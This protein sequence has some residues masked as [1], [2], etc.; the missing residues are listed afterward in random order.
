[1]SY[2]IHY[3]CDT[4]ILHYKYMTYYTLYIIYYLFM[5]ASNNP[6]Q[7]M[8]VERQKVFLCWV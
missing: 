2:I 6:F 1:M 8:Y 7:Y 4:Y 3:V 5:L